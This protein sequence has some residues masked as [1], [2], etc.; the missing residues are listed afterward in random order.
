M[1]D[2]QSEVNLLE[3]LRVRDPRAFG[4]LYDQYGR[5]LFGLAFQILGDT[6]AAEDA[7]QEAF[8][9]IWQHA[10]RLDSRRG[11]LAPLLLAVVHHKASDQLRRRTGYKG[12]KVY[13][14][15]ARTDTASTDPADVAM[16]EQER[17]LLLRAI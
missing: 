17:S 10:D 9:S 14:D 5:R 15:K 7:V 8:L 1:S 16:Q 12:S 2:F 3:G 13:S 4:Q 11:R 6:G